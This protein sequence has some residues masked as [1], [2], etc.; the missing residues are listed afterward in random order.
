MNNKLIFNIKNYSESIK[1]L[2]ITFVIETSWQ[3]NQQNGYVMRMGVAYIASHLVESG[4]Q[5]NIYYCPYTDSEEVLCKNISRE[6]EE[7]KPDIIGFSVTSDNF[8]MLQVSTKYISNNYNLPIIVGGS[9]AIIDPNSVMELTGVS[10][11]CLGEGETPMVNLANALAEGKSITSIDGL[12]LKGQAGPPSNGLIHDINNLCY[13]ERSNYLKKYSGRLRNGWIFQSHRGCPYRCSFCSEDF[14]KKKFQTK[15]YIRARQI[16]SFIE[17]IKHTTSNYSTKFSKFIGFSNPTFNISSTWVFDFCDKY[18]DTIGFPFG[19]DIELSNLTEE[20]AKALAQ[21][22][23]CEAWIGFESGND[24]IRKE[25]LRKNLTTSQAIKNV[26][27]L[28]SAGIKVVLY[29]IVGLPFETEEMIRDTYTTLKKLDADAI[30]PSIFLPFPGTKLGELCFKNGW[31]QRINKDN[32]FPVRGY[33]KSI[34]KYPHITSEKIESYHQKI[35]SLNR[36]Q[37]VS[38]RPVAHT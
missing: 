8:W 5:V 4:H 32:S 34:L 23:C 31:A 3:E 36:N 35:R 33:Y 27:I 13:P 26:E 9:H 14:F 15:K 21:A 7:F 17:E 25:I 12:F 16:D 2:L 19:C 37:P 38:S 10:G 20:M 6:I 30:F 29:A 11:V 22:N 18:S 28:K 24:F 1:F